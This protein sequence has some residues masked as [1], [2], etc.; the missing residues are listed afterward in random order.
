MLLNNGE[1]DNTKILKT[2]TIKMMCKNQLPASV[3][4][5][6]GFGLGFSIILR[7]RY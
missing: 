3:R 2:E 1:L 7:K 5:E 4:S 6:H